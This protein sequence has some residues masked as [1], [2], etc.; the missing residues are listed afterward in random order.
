MGVCCLAQTK[1][2]WLG[3]AFKRDV[4]KIQWGSC[5]LS[6]SELKASFAKGVMLRLVMRLEQRKD[7]PLTV[8]VPPVILWKQGGGFFFPEQGFVLLGFVLC[9]PLVSC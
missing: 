8:L 2:C 3:T 4:R 6:P 9:P 1:T 7:Y 5:A